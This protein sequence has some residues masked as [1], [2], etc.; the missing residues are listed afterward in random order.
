MQK[1]DDSPF[2]RTDAERHEIWDMLVRR[3]SDAYLRQDWSAVEPD[4]ITEGFYG[5]D[6]RGSADASDWRL[7]F[8]SLATYRDEWLRQA[9]E[10][11]RT[12][13]N[14][15]ARAALF[16]ATQLSAIDIQGDIAMAY[17]G[18]NGELPHRDGSATR[19]HWQTLYVCRRHQARW[20]IASFV[21]YLPYESDSGT[22]RAH[23]AAATSQHAGAGPYTPVMG[24]AA[25]ARLFVISGQA[26][27]D[28]QGRVVGS[29]IE[30][31][32]RATLANCRRQ[33]EAA[34]CSLT[35]VFKATVYLTDLTHW[36]AFNVVYRE[37]M[38]AP[39]PARTAVQTGLLPGFLVEI[40]MWAA[41][42]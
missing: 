38:Q 5:I 13:D 36:Q 3:D 14:A 35:D 1:Y 28:E 12:A 31:Q 2:A 4:F 15:R 26:P 27:L 17:K 6:A 21:G 37:L 18:F 8:A 7:S 9:A 34:G 24:V 41:R 40:E 42:R 32:S 23:F 20:K 29:T 10:T 16:H 22:H 19:L 39:F 11:A 30:E 25:D 33:L